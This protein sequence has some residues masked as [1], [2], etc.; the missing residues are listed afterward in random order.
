M[1]TG[2]FTHDYI[3]KVRNMS[4]LQIK[5][6]VLGALRTEEK[7]GFTVFSR[8]TEEQEHLLAARGEAVT[9]RAICNASMKLEFYTCGGEIS[10]DYEVSPGINRQYYSID[11]LVDKVYRYNISKDKN[12]DTDTFTYTIPKA[13]KEQRVTVYFPTTACVKIK[14][15]VVPSDATPHRRKTKILVL[16]DSLYQGYNPNHF[17]NPCMNIFAD[18]FDAQMINQAIGGDCFNKDNLAE[19]NFEPNFITVGYGIND[20]ASGRFK[21]GEDADEYLKRLTEI[22]SEAP[23]FVILPPDYDYLSKTRKNDDLLFKAEGKDFGNQTIEDVRNI[24]A[25]IVK[26]Y[27][28]IIPVNAKDFVPQY[29]EC[30]YTDKVH[31]TDLGNLIFGN[32]VAGEIKRYVPFGKSI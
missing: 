29:P 15:L 6:I 23:V 11:L 13:E 21:N 27:K 14:N 5:D 1:G 32:A 31:F 12:S 9:A 16:G 28:N 10:F 19:I 30:F 17:Q 20:W 26:K 18:F 2:I 3:F 25:E 7:D 4:T 8:F 24:L 22:Y